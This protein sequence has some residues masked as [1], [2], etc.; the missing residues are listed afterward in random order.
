MLRELFIENLAVIERATI[1]FCAGLNVFTGETGAGKSVLIGGLNAALGK[2]VSKDSVRTGAQKATVTAVFDMLPEGV[3]HELENMGLREPR[4]ANGSNTEVD[5]AE[6]AANPTANIGVDSAE[7]AADTEEEMLLL[8]REITADG[9]SSARIN[10]RPTTAAALQTLGNMLCD[11]HGQ[12]DSAALADPAAH[13]AMLDSYGDYGVELEN[14]RKSFRD[15]NSVSRTL[16]DAVKTA[17][18]VK[19]NIERYRRIRD[20]IEPLH[21]KPGEDEEIDFLFE[22]LESAESVRNAAATAAQMISNDDECQSGALER[23]FAAERE[24]L[25]FVK[26]NPGLSGIADDIASAQTL[27]ETLLPTLSHFAG[28][29]ADDEKLRRTRTRKEDIDR[30]KKM[31]GGADRSLQTALDMCAESVRALKLMSTA[32]GDLAELQ[33]HRQKLLTECSRQAREL[34]A[35]RL[36]TA[37]LLAEAI[38]TEL[39]ELDMESVTVT[40][41]VI[42]GKLTKN[43]MDTVEILFAPNPGEDPKPLS[44]TASGGELSRFMLALKSVTANFSADPL[45]MVFDEIDTGVSGRAAAKIGRKLS[46]LAKKSPSGQAIAVTHLAQIAV[47]ADHHLLIEKAVENGRTFTRVNPVTDGARIRE[48]ARI[49]VGDNITELALE[50]AEEQLK[51]ARDAAI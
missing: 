2:R 51:H 16:S 3:I 22:Q 45:V 21:I 35:Q 46:A 24:I 25:P 6:N 19:A 42:T 33:K 9:R 20:D 18:D 49:Q 38:V 4:T 7:N 27:L 11:I 50:N 23:L 47:C 40:F 37:E 31:Y 13:L 8:T 36:K 30:V 32:D 10:N 5:S 17:A 14:Y 43:G 12:H 29:A 26:T 34:S 44:K 1:P 28:E 41:A 48:I 15:L 39:R